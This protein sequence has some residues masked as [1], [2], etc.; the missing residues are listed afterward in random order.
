M[1]QELKT[2]AEFMRRSP[3]ATFCTLLVGAVVYLVMFIIRQDVKHE[4]LEVAYRTE[5]VATE[6]RCAS[7]K[8]ALRK[9]HIAL[10][11]AALRAQE[12]INERLNAAQKRRK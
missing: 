12:K 10:L 3:L 4:A 7:E 6:K 5:I 8:D 9:E 1:L 11:E 2:L